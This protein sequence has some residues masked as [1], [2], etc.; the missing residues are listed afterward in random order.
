MS[1]LTQS[2]IER[3]HKVVALRHV[4][5]L[6]GSADA[7]GGVSVVEHAE[8]LAAV[9]PSVLGFRSDGDIM[10]QDIVEGLIE[11]MPTASRRTPPRLWVP[12]EDQRT[13]ILAAIPLA[14]CSSSIGDI[15][16][17]REIVAP[18]HMLFPIGGTYVGRAIGVKHD[19]ALVT[20]MPVA[21]QFGNG[22]PLRGSA[23]QGLETQADGREGSRASLDQT[24]P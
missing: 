1:V 24:P 6:I 8:A 3:K 18:C 17:Q 15:E 19:R 9:S 14:L 4:T 22:Q 11:L 7:F 12:S 5:L 2:A 21:T 10:R 23:P 16:G 20:E 13:A